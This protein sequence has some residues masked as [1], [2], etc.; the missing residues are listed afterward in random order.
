M[1]FKDLL[2]NILQ[3]TYYN[4]NPPLEFLN[5]NPYLLL[6]RINVTYVRKPNV[7]LEPTIETINISNGS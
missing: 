7:C 4:I 6:A 3:N 5:V 1:K 2:S